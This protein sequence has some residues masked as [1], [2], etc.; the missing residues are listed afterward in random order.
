[1]DH[2]ANS[3]FILLYFKI[4]I[5]YTRNQTLF[6]SHLTVTNIG[7]NRLY[8]FHINIAFDP[9]QFYYYCIEMASL[10]KSRAPVHQLAEL[11]PKDIRIT[12]PKLLSFYETHGQFPN[13]YRSLIWRYLLKLPENIDNFGE[14]VRRGPHPAF[15]GTNTKFDMRSRDRVKSLCSLLAHWSPVLAEVSAVKYSYS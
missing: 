6:A 14:L 7:D 15:E 12:I 2:V 10:M 9:F 13:Q 3:N 11:T 4:K 1:M 5:E 8:C